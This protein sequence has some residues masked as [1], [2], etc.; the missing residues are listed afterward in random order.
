MKA[1]QIIDYGSTDVLEMCEISAP[2]VSYGEIKVR[3]KA[4]SVNPLDWKMRAGMFSQSMPLSFP[5]I[6][7]RDGSGVVKEVGEDAGKWRTGDEVSFMMPRGLGCY[8]EEIVIPFTHAVTKPDHIEVT[9][10]AAYPLVAVTSWIAFLEEYTS[11]LKGKHILIHAGAGGVGSVAIQIARHL[12]A[13]VST[14]CS[15]ANSDYVRSLGA[16]QVVAYDQEDF[17]LALSDVDVVYD[18]MGG[19]VH[20]KSYEVLKTGG[21]MTCIN[22][23]PIEDLSGQFGVSMTIAKV[24]DIAGALPKVAKM[25]ADKS[26]VPQV[27]TVLPFDQVVNA[28]RMLETG[29]AQGKIVLIL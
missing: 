19:D 4:V 9:E 26:L 25:V 14:T 18:T 10:A 15:A 8:A 29:H 2:E 1:I 16:E 22:A 5:A 7:G 20:R 28:H 3:V 12:G 11:G 24:N 13:R 17:T 6:L 27:G 21:H 23:A